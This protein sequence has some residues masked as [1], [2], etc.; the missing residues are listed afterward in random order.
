MDTEVNQFE[1]F[2]AM[3]ARELEIQRSLERIEAAYVKTAEK[4]G[5]YEETKSF[6]EYL[7]SIEKLFMENKLRNRSFELGRD[8]M[9]KV[10]IKILAQGG[11][12]SEEALNMIY[13]YFK[14][15]GQTIDKIYE[16]AAQLMEKYKDDRDCQDFISY[17]RDIFVNFFNAE[18]ERI[19]MDELK[20]RLIKARME[21]LSTNGD[22]DLV[23][24]ENIYKDF[25]SLLNSK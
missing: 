14:K 4:Y 9:I 5:E 3:Y 11:T 12:V 10:R 20:E 2:D 18:K 15:A 24:L 23:T 16:I 21:V 17:V 19:S 6:I 1:N 25:K 8:E 13:G 22:P 7:G